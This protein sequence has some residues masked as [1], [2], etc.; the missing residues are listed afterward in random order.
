MKKQM[1][2]MKKQLIRMKKQLIRKWKHM[3]NLLRNR[4][5]W[6]NKFFWSRHAAEEFVQSKIFDV[7]DSNSYNVWVIGFKAHVAN[8]LTLSLETTLD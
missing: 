1:I 8:S 7:E 4:D 5:G 2:H 3:L 6:K